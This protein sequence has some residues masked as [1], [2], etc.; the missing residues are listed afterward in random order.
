M[1][2][3]FEISVIISTYNRCHILGEALDSVLSEQ[4][5]NA[6]YEVIVVDN[7][8]VDDTRQVVASFIA[9]GHHN[10]RYLLECRQGVSY[11]RNAGIAAAKAPILAFFDDD[12][13]VARNWL[14]GI[15]RALEEHPEVDFVGGKV[16]PRW[17]TPPP[18]WLTRAHWAPLALVDFGEEPLYVNSRNPLCLV[19]ANLAIRRA[20]IVEVGLFAPELQRVRDGI[21][22]MEDSELLIR[23]WRHGRQGLY[24][25]DL[26]VVTRVPDE[27]LT[28]D[29]H[30]R[31][32]TGHGYFYALAHFE[33]I[34]RTTAGWLYGAPAHL[35][36]QA[37]LDAAGWLRCMATGKWDDAF[38]YETRLR[39]F[40][41]FF[42]QRRREATRRQSAVREAFMIIR[43]ALTG[44]A[45][46]DASRKL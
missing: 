1:K 9:R 20:A 2:D 6:R 31:W 11:A 15:K 12:V 22:S 41:G 43:S 25:P 3:N 10:L 34:E 27:R 24:L 7:N 14:S 38:R 19:T 18:P 23:L 44:K 45:A 8:S 36:K 13:C 5:G 28:K 30:R 37:M 33:E 17:E 16:L 39:F 42:R 32:H 35:Y 4:E 29:Y 40:S 26:T 21:G 46:T